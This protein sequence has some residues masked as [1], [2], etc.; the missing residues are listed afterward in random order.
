M[1]RTALT[2]QDI[3][4]A[5]LAPTYSA[6]DAAN[7]HTIAGAD[8]DSFLHVKNTGGGACTVTLNA[9]ARIA[10]LAL[11]NQTVSVPATTGDKMIG[12]LRPDVFGQSDGACYVDLSTATGVTLAAI[13]VKS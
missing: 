3:S 5:G 1:P 4:I 6:G 11:A 2:L 10:G 8:S 7:G 9:T 12:P 13:R